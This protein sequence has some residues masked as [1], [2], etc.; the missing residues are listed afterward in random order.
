M[1]FLLLLPLA[2]FSDIILY[3]SSINVTGSF[4]IFNICDEQLVC[5]LIS[6][7]LFTIQYDE[8][9]FDHRVMNLNGVKIATNLVELLETLNF[10]S[11]YNNSVWYGEKFSCG[12]WLNTCG[13]GQ[14]THP[15]LGK[16]SSYCD[17][18]YKVLCMC[19]STSYQNVPTISPTKIPSKS[20]TKSPTK[21]PSKNP[22]NIPSN[23]PSTSP[24]KVPS[25]NPSISPTK[26]P[27]I[28][29]PSKSPTLTGATYGPS[30]SPTKNPTDPP[31]NL[32][33]KSPS[34]SPTRRPS[35]RPTDSPTK[36]PSGSPSTRP[37]KAPYTGISKQPS[38]T[39]TYGQIVVFLESHTLAVNPVVSAEVQVFLNADP[40][41]RL[42]DIFPRTFQSS[43]LTGSVGAGKAVDGVTAGAYASNQVAH[44]NT[45]SEYAWF[46]IIVDNYYDPYDIYR[47]AIW[48]RTD[49]CCI[50][51]LR[52][53]AIHFAIRSS[54]VG[55][56]PESSIL[57]KQIYIGNTLL[58][59]YYYPVKD[60]QLRDLYLSVEIPTWS[61]TSTSV[62]LTEVELYMQPQPTINVLLNYAFTSQSSTL[63]G[64]Y[65]STKANDGNSA[66][67][68]HTGMTNQPKNYWIIYI[69]SLAIEK[70]EE[71]RLKTPAE[72]GESMVGKII[73]IR[74]S[75]NLDYVPTTSNSADI[76]WNKTISVVSTSSAVS[77]SY[78]PYDVE[79]NRWITQRKFVGFGAI[80]GT[81]FGSSIA[82]NQDESV[83]VVGGYGHASS[84]GAF[85][86]YEKTTY[87][88]WNP[89]Q[90]LLSGTVLTDA[91]REGV[92]VSIW[93][94]TIAV[95][96]DLFNSETGAVF[97]YDLNLGVWEKTDTLIG[98]GNI[99]SSRQGISVSLHGDTLAIGGNG[100]DNWIGAVWIFTRSL[101]VWSQQGS[102]LVGSGYVVGPSIQMG[103]SVSLWGDTVAFGGPGDDDLNGGV[104][105]YIRTASVW[106]QQGSKLTPTGGLG[107]KYF[108]ASVSLQRDILVVGAPRDDNNLGS[109][110]VFTRS[111]GVWTQH[112]RLLG[113]NPIANNYQGFSVS[114]W[115]DYLAVGGTAGVG[116]AHIYKLTSNV[117]REVRH[118]TGSGNIGNSAQGSSICLRNM[119][120]SIG[121][122][123]DNSNT[124][125]LWS[126]V[127]DN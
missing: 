125:A 81:L 68:S 121:G 48:P 49:G 46:K 78:R 35:R 30:S 22:T 53:N 96:I 76:L 101:G 67:Y 115:N 65:I 72:S 51:Q 99:F 71:I 43:D 20:P 94:T 104:W 117:W 57:G 24:T 31:T 11:V 28:A 95:G 122:I 80:T 84:K 61:P 123:T 103:E 114:L 77:L 55:Y 52:D 92:S 1:I 100:D 33:T 5:D 59:T 110:Y 119:T 109:I 47:I 60:Y 29:S 39:P 8:Q 116:S 98:S 58:P 108:G 70:I 111:A 93:D 63:G 26:S 85:W 90:S 64:S 2:I 4:D 88:S 91:F 38:K 6:P 126:F 10:S 19:V 56:Y 105:V 50:N 127:R 75:T 124:G 21:V 86:I 89:V 3:P 14:I 107:P 44:T 102:K 62:M 69:G 45:I 34:K 36:E 118:V 37:S 40:T 18:S 12:N 66:T 15:V 112:S 13:S 54:S 87:N 83:M 97:I 16:D 9:L 32:P 73:T 23:S 41:N 120:V 74:T 113:S 82:M 27:I 42:A 25:K 79:M 106:S 7:L 17:E